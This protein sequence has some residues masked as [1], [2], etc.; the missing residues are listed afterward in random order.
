MTAARRPDRD[1]RAHVE[2]IVF[3]HHTP[4]G[5]AYDVALIAAILASVSVVMLETVTEIQLRFGGALRAAEWFFTILFTVEYAVRLWCTRQPLRYAGSFFGIVDLLSILP[6]YLSIA[7]PG[8][9]ALLTVRALRLLRVFRVL[10]LGQY[11]SEA[12][13][14]GHALA[15]SRQKIT[16]FLA[17]VATLVLVLGSLM[18]LVEGPSNG[19]TSIPRSV[20][21]AIVTLTTVGYGDITPHTVAG[22]VLA[23]VVMILG[24]G[25]IAVPTG[26]VTVEMGRAPVEGGRACRRCGLERH[27]VDARHCKRC[28]EPLD[29]PRS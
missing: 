21:W 10:K 26:I 20:Y 14:L 19:F 24:Y 8:A 22:Q 3:G 4:A 28:G 18:Y 2:E 27:D 12:S 13:H 11:T 23:S 17:V 1:L 5:K 9:Q 25:I 16:V 15:R 7:L 6:T 29:P